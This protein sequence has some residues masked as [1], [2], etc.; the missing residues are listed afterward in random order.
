MDSKQVIKG[1]DFRMV[2]KFNHISSDFHI[3]GNH[4]PE[5]NSL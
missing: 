1:F 3:N 2:I 4:C 5:T